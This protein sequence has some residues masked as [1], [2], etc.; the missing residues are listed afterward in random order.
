MSQTRHNVV[1]AIAA[2]LFFAFGF[3]L[4][5]YSEANQRE[6]EISNRKLMLT[7]ASI[8]APN[9]NLPKSEPCNTSLTHNP[10]DSQQQ[11]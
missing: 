1:T 9:N 7:V 11:R 10:Q 8:G 6:A 5:A 3:A 4:G 2:I